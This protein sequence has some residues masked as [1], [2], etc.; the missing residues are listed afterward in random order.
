MRRH[1]SFYVL[2]LAVF[3]IGKDCVFCE[4]RTDAEEKLYI[5]SLAV[6]LETPGVQEAM[7]VLF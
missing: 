6:K 1:A 7:P 2:P 5:L 4:V 3:V